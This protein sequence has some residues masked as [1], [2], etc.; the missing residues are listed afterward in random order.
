MQFWL[1]RGLGFAIN[2]VEVAFDHFFGLHGWPHEYVEFDTQ[3]LLRVAYKDRIEA[4]A[5][6]VQTA[7]FAPNEARRFRGPAGQAPA[8]T[9]RASS[10]SS[11]PALG[12]GETPPRRRA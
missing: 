7:I 2:H 3:A 9:S 8:A 10:N 5:R 12:V 6:G 4:L 1:A 11:R